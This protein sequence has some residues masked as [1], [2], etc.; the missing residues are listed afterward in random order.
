MEH[1][2]LFGKG[3]FTHSIHDILI[4]VLIVEYVSGP[5]EKENFYELSN[6]N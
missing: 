6:S 2:E 1:A 5:R 4:L 3:N